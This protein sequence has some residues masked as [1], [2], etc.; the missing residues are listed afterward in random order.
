MLLRY[1]TAVNNTCFHDIEKAIQRQLVEDW[2]VGP[3]PEDVCEM[4]HEDH[5]INEDT[6]RDTFREVLHCPGDYRGAE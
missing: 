2:P 3:V 4:E 6:P 5:G 1:F